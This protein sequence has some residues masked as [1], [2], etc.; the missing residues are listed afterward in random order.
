MHILDGANLHDTAF[1]LFY[2]AMSD[3]CNLKCIMCSTTKH[4]DEIEYDIVKQELPL[5]KWKSVIDNIT[6]FKIN[7]I[8]FGGGE[9]L[10]KGD[11]LVE[12]I[13]IIAS[14]NIK[15]DIVTN[16]TLLMDGFLEKLSAYKDK[17]TFV[18]SI[19]GSEPQNDLIRGNGTFKKIVKAANLVRQKHW[20]FFFTSVLMP[21]NFL[22]YI[23]FLKFLM[24]EFALVP[25]EI[26]PIIPHN[27]VYYI[28]QKFILTEEKLSALKSILSFLNEY[29]IDTQE[30]SDSSFNNK[31]N[32]CRPL[33]VINKYWD[34][35]NNKLS[36]E[37]VQCKMG[38]ESFNINRKG[39]MWICGKELEYPLYKYSLEEVLK[40]EE[41]R[42]E[43]KRVQACESSCFTGLII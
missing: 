32:L 2:I 28:R 41:Y 7:T 16:A 10:L 40:T 31:L 34:Y 33:K 18:I 37:R 3:R 43:M 26:Q 11:I 22:G 14:K 13:P 5:E 24:K 17:I 1:Y 27:E 29:G 35:F 4:S 20:N 25:L 15:I 12:L 21:E 6:R 42:S 30:V 9:P 19:D 39:N 23:D 8:S 38:T 36:A